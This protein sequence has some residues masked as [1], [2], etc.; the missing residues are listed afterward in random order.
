MDDTGEKFSKRSVILSRLAKRSTLYVSALALALTASLGLASFEFRPAQAFAQSQSATHDKLPSFAPLVARVKSSV[1]S[2]RVK[3]D[4]EAKVASNEDGEQLQEGNPFEGTPFER[5]FNNPNSPFRHFH[6]PPGHGRHM[7][8]AQGSGFFISPDGYIVTN[9]HVASNAVSLEVIAVD[10]KIYSAKVVGSDSKTDLALLKVDGRDDFPFVKFSRGGVEVGDWVVA[11]GNPF[12]LG[13]T[14]T[15]GIVSARGRDIGE[16]PYDDFLQID[17][18]VNKGN[19]GGPTFNQDGDVIGVN[20]AIYSPSG[21]SIGIA[22]DIPASTAERVVAA[23][24]EHGR[25]TRG[26]LGVHIQALTPELADSLGLKSVTG[27]LVA[28]PQ[29]G[30]PAEKAGIR[31]GDL[32]TEV[33]GAEVK[34]ARDLAKKIADIPP[35]SDVTIALNRGGQRKTLTVNIGELPEKN[36]PRANASPAPSKTGMTELGVRV[37]PAGDISAGERAGLAVLAVEPGS[38]AAEA[39]LAEG[40]IILKVGDQDVNRVDDLKTALAG[41]SKDGR[42]NALALVKRNGDQRFIALPAKVG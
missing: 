32:I 16:G 35:G 14:V 22:F 3:A 13:G 23:L 9:N 18:P 8:M 17:A 36:A 28:A 4:L 30:S 2:I 40:D 31:A 15:A 38:K 39:G 24:K 11:M 6:M 41:A 42:K 27:A 33:N 37:A 34:D 1:V 12:G 19:S 29:D 10:G 21:G 26:W 25:V 7:V 5:F 20:T